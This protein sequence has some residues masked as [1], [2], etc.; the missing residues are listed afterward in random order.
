MGWQDGPQSEL[1][2]VK[3][4]LPSQ[5]DLDTMEEPSPFSDTGCHRHVQKS[6]EGS[7]II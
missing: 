1:I 3:M 4:E 5:D 6:R 2:W 7:G